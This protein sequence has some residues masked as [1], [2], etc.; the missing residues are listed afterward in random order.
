M[1]ALHRSNLR[2]SY[3]VR[4][5]VMR[6]MLMHSAHFGA[7]AILLLCL[8]MICLFLDAHGVDVWNVLFVSLIWA[9]SMY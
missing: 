2:R 9:R 1:G 6:F 5:Q 3:Y 8:Y 7:P 4:T